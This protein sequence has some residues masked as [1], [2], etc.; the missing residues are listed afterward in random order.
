[1]T[2]LFRDLRSAIINQ[3]QNKLFID[4][5]Q[6]EL[7]SPQELHYNKKAH[8]SFANKG[9][10]VDTK[11]FGSTDGVDYLSPFPEQNRISELYAY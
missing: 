1:M 8:K 11:Q 10:F 9:V 5:W 6:I 3:P 2:F 7:F 4:L